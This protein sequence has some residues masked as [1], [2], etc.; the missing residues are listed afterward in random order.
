MNTINFIRC[1]VAIL[2]TLTQLS[3]SL[4]ITINCCGCS[5]SEGVHIDNLY[6]NKFVQSLVYNKLHAII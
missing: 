2:L 5:R 3:I 4:K 1:V 6:N